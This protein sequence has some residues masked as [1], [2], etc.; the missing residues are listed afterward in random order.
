MYMMHFDASRLL[1]LKAIH[2]CLGSFVNVDYGRSF[3]VV[4]SVLMGL[5]SGFTPQCTLS[6]M[7]GLFLVLEE[8]V[9]CSLTKDPDSVT[10]F[11]FKYGEGA[12]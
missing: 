11:A 6:C 4:L 10:S 9:S 3:Q 7:G 12:R 2:E 5:C 8:V 1:G